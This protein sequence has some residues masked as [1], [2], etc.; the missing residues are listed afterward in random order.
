MSPVRRFRPTR[1][2][3]LLLAGAGTFLPAGRAVAGGFLPLV[4]DV[5]LAGARLLTA[6]GRWLTG[7][8][9][10][11]STSPH[12]ITR[13]T[14]RE[15]DG[16]RHKLDAD[17]V[18][19]I[20]APMT[21]AIR[22]AARTDTTSARE[23]SAPTG[24]DA[25]GVASELIFDAIAW[26]DESRRVILQ[27]VNPGFDRGIRVYAHE[28]WNKRIT[29]IGDRAASGEEPKTFVVV[30]NGERPTSLNKRNYDDRFL[31]LFGDCPALVARVP[32]R[33]R[34]LRSF[35]DHLL[36]Y[37][38]ECSPSADAGPAK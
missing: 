38:R 8:V 14:L 30:K 4:G 2:V 12:G 23:S 37:D 24:D 7:E 15:P 17:D 21:R 22:R 32:K 13:I 20:L 6:E 19:Q 5:P 10:V 36:A 16:T 31:E 1:F 28:D 26:P 27:R 11:R 29:S 3:L 35:A 9:Q 18:E 34:E 33:E 25:L